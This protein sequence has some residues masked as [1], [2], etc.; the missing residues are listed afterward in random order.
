MVPM[1]TNN[2]FGIKRT[3][4]LVEAAP[5]DNPDEFV[6]VDTQFTNAAA[7]AALGR[8]VASCD[9]A[10]AR[11]RVRRTTDRDGSRAYTVSVRHYRGAMDALTAA[12]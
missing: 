4:W 8:F 7:L 6:R 2:A 1:S 5:V 12:S 11:V 10:T 9:N 3:E